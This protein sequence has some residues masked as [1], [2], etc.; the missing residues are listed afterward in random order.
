MEMLALS[1][2]RPDTVAD[3]LELRLILKNTEILKGQ[4]FEDIGDGLDDEDRCDIWNKFKEREALYGAEGP[5]KVTD[6][7]ITPKIRTCDNPAYTMCLLLNYFG[8]KRNAGDT[9]KI[10]ERLSAFAVKN[11]LDGEVRIYGYP[12]ANNLTSIITEMNEKLGSQRIPTHGDRGVDLIVWK[13]FKDKHPSQIVVLMQCASGKNWRAKTRDVGITAWS[14]Y[15][16]WAEEVMK[17]F[18]TPT[19]IERGDAFYEAAYDAG[20]LLDRP[21]LYHYTTN[22]REIDRQLYDEIKAWCRPKISSLPKG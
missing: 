17:G 5:F 3:W 10:F 2:T 6:D 12:R 7:S 19:I 15:V 13:P 4:I 9:G 18:S 11:Y 14:H 8:N 22:L 16:N 20:V 1:D 21:R